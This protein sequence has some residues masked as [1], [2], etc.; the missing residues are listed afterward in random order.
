MTD[1]S[2]GALIT[3]LGFALVGF[4][5][6]V[7]PTS[8]SAAETESSMARGGRLYDKWFK[9]IG[10]PKPKETH[11]AWP[12]SNTEKKG[13]ATQRCKA[14]HGWDLMG[15]DGAYASGS[16]KT[17]IKGLR[18]FQGADND[19]VISAMKNKL[20]GYSGKME[21][22]D[23]TDLA[24]FV[25]K[26]QVDMDKL[27]DRASKKAHGDAE[28]GSAYFNTVCANCHGKDGRLPKDMDP[29]GK[30]ANKNPWEIVQKILN[31][32]PDEEMPAL[33]AFDHQ[34]SVDILA[35]LQTLPKK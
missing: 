31:G 20:H 26:G 28:K 35:Y 23:F 24:N 27:I 7:Y 12:A 9:V 21:E 15:K 14:C 10:A 4:V 34:I 1:I 8:V 11:P 3:A 16:Y 18:D 5:T 25:T 29:L 32:Q 19:K 22:Q 13:N 33:R 30:L 17:G 2:K 6:T